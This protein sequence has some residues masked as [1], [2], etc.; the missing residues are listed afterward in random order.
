MEKVLDTLLAETVLDTA[1]RLSAVEA[2]LTVMEQSID[3]LTDKLSPLIDKMT[4][5]EAKFG[6]IFFV[7]G[8]V[9]TFFLATWK[10]ILAK[11]GVAN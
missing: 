10:Y 3:K 8:C 6:A 2:R 9:W 4:R 7:T 11:F 1:Q 5:W